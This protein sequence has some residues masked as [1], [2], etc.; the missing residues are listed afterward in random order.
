MAAPIECARRKS[1][2]VIGVGGAWLAALGWFRTT[3][4]RSWAL[5]ALTALS[6]LM[7][8]G[9]RTDAAIYS[10]I[11]LAIASFLGFERTRTYLLK[12]LLPAGLVLMAV[13]FF[14]SSAICEATVMQ[15]S[16]DPFG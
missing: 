11:G 1:W 13:I 7:A 14:F 9:A 15:T 3:G 12:L 6:V 16:F 8:A 4:A 10:I 5:G 2:A